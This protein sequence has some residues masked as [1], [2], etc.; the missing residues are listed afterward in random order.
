MFKY[1][2]I[3]SS[4]LIKS[5]QSIEFQVNSNFSL[6]F[7]MH[8]SIV[9]WLPVLLEKLCHSD[10][11]FFVVWP[12]LSVS[13]QRLLL[14]SSVLKC[15]SN[16]C[17]YGSFSHSLDVAL[18]EPFQSRHSFIIALE[19]SSPVVLC[20]DVWL[21]GYFHGF[22]FQVFYRIFNFSYHFSQISKSSFK[23]F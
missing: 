21:P 14:I 13:S 6:E 1:I 9:F 16:V 18:G 5:Y 23:I 8:C 17:G 19:I 4:W 2:F 10:P 22:V 20:D 12:G 11:H 7:W 3:L 15:R